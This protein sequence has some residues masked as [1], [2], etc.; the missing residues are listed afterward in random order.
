MG[1]ESLDSIPTENWPYGIALQ[2]VSLLS[3]TNLWAATLLTA[4]SG[5]IKP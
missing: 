1:S 3:G 5:K 2:F 4:N